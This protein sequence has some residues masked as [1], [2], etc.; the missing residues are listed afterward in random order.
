MQFQLSTGFHWERIGLLPYKTDCFD[1]VILD[2]KVY[3]RTADKPVLQYTIDTNVW[4][5]LPPSPVDGRNACTM[6]SLNGQ[7]VLAGGHKNKLLGVPTDKITVWD[8]EK[9][10]WDQKAYPP[11]PLA[12]SRA[13]CAG[14]KQYLIVAGGE[15]MVPVLNSVDILDTSN[16]TWYHAPPMPHKG[17]TLKMLVAGDY[18]YVLIIGQNDFNISKITMRVHLP[19]LISRK[20]TDSKT[21]R[22]ANIW[23]RLP[24]VPYYASSLFAIGDQ[25]FSAGGRKDGLLSMTAEA[26]LVRSSKVSSD[27]HVLNLNIG[28]WVKVGEMPE[29]F[30]DGVC[31]VLPNG[32]LLQ[33]GGQTSVYGY[34]NTVY[35]GESQSQS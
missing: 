5:S 25:I 4:D 11:M 34:L 9:Q 19:N 12:R 26:Y 14:Y 29:A 8:A 22:D 27:I 31:A 18:L 20:Q 13:G 15:R 2:G 16:Q 17:N 24:D 33:V 6:T 28:S 23:E 3:I 30:W 32:K 35:I 7:L 21:V 1:P 10:Q